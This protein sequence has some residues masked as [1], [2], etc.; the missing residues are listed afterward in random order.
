MYPQVEPL[1]QLLHT[2]SQLRL[3]DLAIGDDGR[4]RCMLGQFVA[5]RGATPPKLPS[6]S[7]DPARGYGG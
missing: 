5:S 2:L 7:S 3:S 4:N 6:T 1:R